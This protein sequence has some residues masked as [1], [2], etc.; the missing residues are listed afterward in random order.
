V[1]TEVKFSFINAGLNE[2]PSRHE[3]ARGAASFPPLGVLYLG[4]VLRDYGVDVSALDQPAGGYTAEE[5]VRWVSREDPDVVGVSSIATSG[6]AAA[7][8]CEK[9]KEWNPNIIILV[10]NMH[11]T[12]N[13][14]K[15][16]S[17]YSSV[18]IAVR[19]EGERT[20]VELA[21]RLDN[22]GYLS[23]VRGITYRRGDAIV[24]NPDQPLIEDLDSIPFPDRKLLGSDYHCMM[25]GAN[26]AP[27]KFTSL[28][29]S[30]GCMFK[31]RFCNCTQFVSNR[32]RARSAKN[33]LEELSLLAGDGY[34]QLVFADD[35]FITN[36]KRAIEICRSMRREKMDFDFIS[37][38]RV[39]SCSY[40]LLAEMAKAGCRIMYFGIECA[41]QRML[42]YYRKQATVEQA[43]RAV[44]TAK[45]AG[46]DVVIGSFVVGGPDETREEVQS[47]F[48]F[49]KRIPID[50]PQ[51]NVLKAYP[52]S[53]MW[54]ELVADGVLNEEEYW[55]TGVPVSKVC[56]GAVPFH[57]LRQMANHAMYD[58]LRRPGFLLR[59]MA[60]SLKSSYRM[61]AI[62]H[63]LQRL[64]DVRENLR[65]VV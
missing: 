53:Q 25:V 40:E 54:G 37:E 58:F 46:I 27:K 60:M 49:A 29:S 36:P 64:G 55:E 3:S 13:A 10:G 43:E 42:D 28:V 32:W 16:L 57:E 62:L 24:S 35:T 48:D 12:F 61:S 34:R 65:H 7:H 30:R 5:V 51:Y 17:K 8:I 11:A 6:R 33:T 59:E 26:V 56:P 38:G 23:E 19:G 4:A 47:T 9:V 18:N 14:R 41:S 44:R 39:D 52:G 1:S 45:S 63:N 21:S 20:I 22:G 2:G 15:L 50:L 31:C